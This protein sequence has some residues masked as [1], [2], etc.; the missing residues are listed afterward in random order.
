MKHINFFHVPIVTTSNSNDSTVKRFSFIAFKTLRVMLGFVW[1][2]CSFKSVG[3]F[4]VFC[5]Y[6]IYDNEL[7]NVRVS[8][9]VGVELID[10]KCFSD[11]I[12]INENDKPT[13]KNT[14]TTSI[15]SLESPSI[16]N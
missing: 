15:K 11:I 4:F 16:F 8:Y 1:T 13:K 10:V 9:W 5:C 2:L 14:E 12:T 3:S 7:Y 6:Q